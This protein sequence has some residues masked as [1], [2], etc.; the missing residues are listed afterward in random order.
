[1]VS[2]ILGEILIGPFERNFLPM[3]CPG[4]AWLCD[5]TLLFSRPA[6]VLLTAASFLVILRYSHAGP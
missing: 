4:C 5:T 6:T 2:E 3:L 1:M